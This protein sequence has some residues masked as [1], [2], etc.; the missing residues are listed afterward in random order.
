MLSAF[1]AQAVMVL[2]F[3][4]VFPHLS[5]CVSVCVRHV[6]QFQFFPHFTDGNTE[7][8]VKHLHLKSQCVVQAR[9][10]WNRDSVQCSLNFSVLKS[11]SQDAQKLWA[12][13]LLM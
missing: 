5:K 7:S 1:K 11:G 8:E 12:S 2:K 9:F 3:T 10:L 4:Y 13:A 6:R